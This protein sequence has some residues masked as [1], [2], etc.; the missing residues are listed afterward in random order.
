MA[1]TTPTRTP[2]APRVV[3]IGAGFGGMH[4]AKRLAGHP[5]QVTFTGTAK[6]PA[7]NEAELPAF[8]EEPSPEQAA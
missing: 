2:S 1:H 5:A 3:I 8:S 6:M 7:C 4:A